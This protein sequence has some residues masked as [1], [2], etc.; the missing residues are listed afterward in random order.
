MFVS[1]HGDVYTCGRGVE[2]QL[3]RPG[4]ARAVLRVG[5]PLEGEKVVKVAAGAG[6]T[7][8]VT[9]DGRLYEWG[10]VFEDANAKDGVAHARGSEAFAK[11]TPAAVAAAP[12]ATELAPVKDAFSDPSLPG[13]GSTAAKLAAAREAMDPL[14][15]AR[16]A[17]IDEKRVW[18]IAGTVLPGMAQDLSQ[19]GERQRR[20]VIRSA[21][22]FLAASGS[23]AVEQDGGGSGTAS[24]RRSASRSFDADVISSGILQMKL[25][26]TPVPAP[27]P[28]PYLEAMGVRVKA[29]GAG[30]AHIVLVAADGR[31]FSAGFNDG[32][33]LGLGHRISVPTFQPVV[34]AMAA[35]DDG[36]IAAANR[37]SASAASA[38]SAVPGSE[39]PCR[40]ENGFAGAVM[41]RT[42]P[43][44]A[45][46]HCAAPQFAD[47]ACGQAHTL[48][49]DVDGRVWGCGGGGLGQLGNDSGGDR[50]VP[51]L[52][53]ALPVTHP[54][55]VDAAAAAETASVREAFA[56][57]AAASGSLSVRRHVIALGDAL[58]AH[59][60]CRR[61]TARVVSLA[62]GNNHSLLLTADGAVWGMGHAEYG[63]FSL[64]PFAGLDGDLAMPPRYYYRPRLVGAS[65]GDPLSTQLHRHR[66][67]DVSAGSQFCACRTRDGS[68]ITFGWNSYGVLGSMEE[69]ASASAGRGAPAAAAPLI[70]SLRGAHDGPAS[71]GAAAAGS[72][73]GQEDGSARPLPGFGLGRPALRVVCGRD[74]V[75]CL[76]LPEGDSAAQSWQ[77]MVSPVTAGAPASRS[78]D[79][80]DK[81]ALQLQ[82]RW[83]D[84][85]A[86]AKAAAAA[87]DVLVV[88][89]EPR[90]L[91]VRTARAASGKAA[92]AA[93]EAAASTAAEQRAAA[94]SEGVAVDRR[95]IVSKLEALLGRLVPK[96][97]APAEPAARPAADAAG[98]DRRVELPGGLQVRVTRR[99]GCLAAHWPVLQARFSALRGLDAAVGAGEVAE[100]AGRGVRVL[101]V[102]AASPL[103]ED[104]LRASGASPA[105]AP[106]VVLAVLGVNALT[107]IDAVQYAYSDRMQTPKHRAR[108]VRGL[109][110]LLGAPALA[111]RASLVL[112]EERQ[113]AESSSED[114]AD[115]AAAATAAAVETTAAAADIAP[116]GHPASIPAQRSSDWQADM[117]WLVRHGL[118]HGD[119]C[120]A[121]EEDGDDAAAS[122]KAVATTAAVRAHR[123]ALLRCDFFRVALQGGRFGSEGKGGLALPG[124]SASVLKLVVDWLHRANAEIVTGETVLP[125]LEAARRL[126]IDDLLRE[127]EAAAIAAVDEESAAAVLEVAEALDLPRLANAARK[128]GLD[129]SV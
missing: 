46:S 14:A 105:A 77:S 112:C 113:A 36:A 9:E 110:R 60:A 127:A 121:A 102:P 84:A 95:A 55:E 4:D 122:A 20:V 71:P 15:I 118:E 52:V 106:R 62:C 82:S 24:E 73:S 109:A 98:D 2:G 27:R 49:L 65:I 29:V 6:F 104:L 37:A 57:E 74:H 117:A 33:Q 54:D 41:D 108:Q 101:A 99:R 61:R 51:S 81:A 97:A 30:H 44:A 8:A 87:A 38:A 111:A 126:C 7:L 115:A 25:E 18:E 56:Q 58:L 26:R 13:Q 68:V 92:A 76:C 103:G 11:W 114:E 75:L 28:L 63:Q 32:G 79:G 42:R 72:G 107:T 39:L 78:G 86:A 21:L 5:G 66:V 47:V 19:L 45:H 64:G 34:R 53:V 31:A 91:R 23:A 89:L 128:A 116:A 35:I 70:P 43:L 80:P 40:A 17:G 59:A 3:G 93:G 85:G 69:R 125:L 129:A 123:V 83:D 1:N 120:I 96:G 94:H 48:L 100:L 67:A 22:R 119:V 16:A 124:V 12:D 50:T 90:S 88:A 10:M